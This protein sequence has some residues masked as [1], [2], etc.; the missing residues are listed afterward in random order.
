MVLRHTPCPEGAMR[1]SHCTITRHDVHRLTLDRLTTHL[2]LPD[3][4]RRCPAAVLLGVLL[5]A[6][7]RLCSIW[8]ATRH[9]AAAPSDQTV[10]TAL[11]RSLP[12]R[13]EL[14]RRLNRALTADL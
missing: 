14:E 7:A 6:A 12:D 2:R 1:Q 8:A 5:A 11:A 13:D 4:S 10:R 3:H 9:L